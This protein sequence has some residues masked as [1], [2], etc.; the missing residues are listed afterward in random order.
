M[1]RRTRQGLAAVALAIL[2]AP[3][4]RAAE[5]PEWRVARGEVR[6]LCP[7]TV[8]GSFEA[9]T[10]SLTGALTPA[11]THAAAMAGTLAVDLRTLETGIGLRNQHLR[12]TCLEVGKGEGFVRR[13]GP[14]VRV[15]AGFAVTLADFGIAKPRYLGIGVKSEVQVK[16]SLV[17]TPA[18]APAAGSR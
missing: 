18:A 9:R 2:L 8:G 15:E 4:G 17:A 6:V 1:N 16:A 3:N 12:D 5:G 7:L 14:A 11:S 10:T 13:E